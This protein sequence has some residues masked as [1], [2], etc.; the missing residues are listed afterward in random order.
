MLLKKRNT[1][2]IKYI[3]NLLQQKQSQIDGPLA[4]WINKEN[5][6]NFAKLD[7]I[8]GRKPQ[9]G[10]KCP[11]IHLSKYVYPTIA[12][13]VKTKVLFRN[14][15]SRSTILTSTFYGNLAQTPNKSFL[16]YVKNNNNNNNFK[17]ME[18]VWVTSDV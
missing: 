7:G 3:R 2:D 1:D 6:T 9:K 11:V 15:F 13:K 4:F 17:E 5:Q 14:A 16:L 10:N 12:I 18:L 8:F